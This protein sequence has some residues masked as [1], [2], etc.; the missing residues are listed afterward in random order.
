MLRVMN[1]R[2]SISPTQQL[3]ASCLPQQMFLFLALDHLVFSS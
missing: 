2:L 1:W 3:T